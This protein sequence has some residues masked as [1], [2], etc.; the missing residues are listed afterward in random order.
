V[1]GSMSDLVEKHE[2]RTRK[3]WIA[4]EVIGQ[5]D[6]KGKWKNVNNEN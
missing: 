5:M 2:R 6:G 1:L 3:P 4:Q